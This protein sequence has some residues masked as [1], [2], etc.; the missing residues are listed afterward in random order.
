MYY[1]LGVRKKNNRPKNSYINF[2][3]K[4]TKNQGG[5]LGL[6]LPPTNFFDPQAKFFSIFQGSLLWFFGVFNAKINEFLD[7]FFRTPKL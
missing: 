4:T 3:S 5:I 1:S 7:I 6:T 2:A